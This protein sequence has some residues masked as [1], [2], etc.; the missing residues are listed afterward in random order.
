MFVPVVARF[1]HPLLPAALCLPSLRP[2]MN[3]QDRFGH[4]HKGFL[5]RISLVL[6]RA[7]LP[8]IL[9]RK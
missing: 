8:L 9:P 3:I 2:A 1:T 7:G 5:V 6:E 4:F